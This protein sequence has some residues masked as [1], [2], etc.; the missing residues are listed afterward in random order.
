MR[1]GSGCSAFIGPAA[2]VS[3]CRGSSIVVR[4]G[5]KS[6]FGSV[7]FGSVR[8]LSLRGIGGDGRDVSRSGSATFGGQK[9]S[10]A[11]GSNQTNT[12]ASPSIAA[13]A[14]T[15]ATGRQ[16]RALDSVPVGKVE[17]SLT[18]GFERS[19]RC[20]TETSGSSCLEM[21]CGLGA[22]SSSANVFTSSRASALNR[23]SEMSIAFRRESGRSEDGRDS[24]SGMAA[25]PTRTGI[26]FRPSSSAL[27]TS[28]RTVSLKLSRR[29][30][31]FASRMLHQVGPISTKTISHS[32]RVR[33]IASIKSS[34]YEIES[35]SIKT[36]SRPRA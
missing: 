32:A 12:P 18:A 33:E 22:R 14:L 29:R 6:R 35:M 27:D 15:R 3:L 25:P 16:Y 34:P 1:V 30:A 31:P 10:L 8:A 24:V 13:A 9:A 19:D 5:D 11:E 17:V 2:D 36:C 26:T 7:D 20:P 23:R 28:S 4:V 21:D